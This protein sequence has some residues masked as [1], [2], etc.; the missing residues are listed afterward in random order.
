VRKFKFK[1][2]WV[3]APSCRDV[4]RQEWEGHCGSNVVDNM[5]G[6]V[7]KCSGKL[8]WWNKEVFDNVTTK[9]RDLEA[10]LKG[11]KDGNRRRQMQ[12]EIR[13]WQH[14]EEIM[15]WQCARSNFLKYDD[16]ITRWFHSRAS[17]KE[18]KPHC[19]LQR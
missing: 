3:L 2:M 12:G 19:E 10:S 9:F 18:A 5:L 4:I 11:L 17:I 15:W 1:N 13:S 14:K 8:V 6:K 7:G 16:A